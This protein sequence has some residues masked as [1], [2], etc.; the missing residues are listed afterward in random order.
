[1]PV[2]AK[3]SLEQIVGILLGVVMGQK[4]FE[5]FSR[6]GRA[7]KLDTGGEVTR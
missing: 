5:K 3:L 2:G 1:M 6:H 7:A 4:V